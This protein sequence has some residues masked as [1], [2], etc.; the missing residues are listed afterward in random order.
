MN[1]IEP[2]V[3]QIRG[4]LN[5]NESSEEIAR[6]LLVAGI[7][8][9]LQAPLLEQLVP[10]STSPSETSAVE[11][12]FSG[13][14]AP[15]TN[16]PPPAEPS[17]EP[18]AAAVPEF[19]PP[20]PTAVPPT[21]A[22]PGSAIPASS[23]PPAAAPPATA[24]LPPHD[25][26]SVLASVAVE[27]SA[28][29][30]GGA[31]GH[32]EP[33]RT[34]GSARSAETTTTTRDPA[35]GQLPRLLVDWGTPPKVGHVVRPRFMLLCP[36]PWN[37]E[38]RVHVQVDPHLDS[39]LDGD[40]APIAPRGDGLWEFH[41][42][43]GM[44]TAG[45]DCRPGQYLL[46]VRIAFDGLEMA[47]LSRFFTCTIR[48]DVAS[49][50]Q[51]ERTLEI[52]GD[53]QSIINLHGHD[54]QSFGR[55]VLRG[56][57]AGILNLQSGLE[58]GSAP[59]KPSDSLTHEYQLSIDQQRESRVIR[60]LN[61]THREPLDRAAF[62][63]QDGR[64]ILLLPRRRVTI[65]RQRT[66]DVVVRCL[67]RSRENDSISRK[68]SRTHLTVRL[69]ENGL[70]LA[71]TSSTGVC[72]DSE[73]LDGERILPLDEGRDPLEVEFGGRQPVPQ[74]LFAWR[75]QLFGNERL[76]GDAGDDKLRWNAVGE[77]PSRLW[78]L[79]TAS[80]IDAARL[81]RASNLAGREDYV[82]LYRQ[83]C[84]GSSPDRCPVTIPGADVPPVAARLLY[85]GRTFWVENLGGPHSL[86]VDGADLPPQRIAPLTPGS[87]LQIGST[88]LEF[89][90]A[91]QLLLEEP[92]DSLGLTDA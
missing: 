31:A 10:A 86:K 71:D 42:P 92:S 22:P 70:Q 56:G 1:W 9:E 15:P 81:K 53:G 58:S 90:R 67:P 16:P 55:V 11:T 21:A 41:A 87:Q 45:S 2:V 85:M 17:T 7:P 61:R 29:E 63:L 51:A 37:R 32:S 13:Q 68:I 72:L 48:L 34:T 74:I 5:G 84:I 64:Q 36:G 43:F 28:R 25:P 89:R 50:S 40:F 91:A 44:T 18:P 3:N 6:L 46:H 20:P 66:S 4:Q 30:E 52:D 26:P 82:M 38:P 77:Q 24:P 69:E 83:A 78:Q 62:V 76:A 60:A 8:A 49:S 73:L 35:G 57:D 47:D 19:T 80:G 39:H 65:G 12:A 14:P 27:P 23:P 54:L 33:A 59:E 79:S 75:L 88:V